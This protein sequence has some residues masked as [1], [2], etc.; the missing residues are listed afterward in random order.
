MGED[1][2]GTKASLIKNNSPEDTPV[3]GQYVR[4]QITRQK[5]G[6]ENF[7]KLRCLQATRKGLRI[8]VVNGTTS[9]IFIRNR[10]DCK[11]RS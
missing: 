9:P 5:A 8:I 3:K 2:T 11:H 6:H 1:A 10:K 4:V 7:V